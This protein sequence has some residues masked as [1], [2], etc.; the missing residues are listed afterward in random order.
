MDVPC[1]FRL[2][3]PV[4]PDACGGGQLAKRVM[5]RGKQSCGCSSHGAMLACGVVV[6]EGV[7]LFSSIA[8]QFPGFSCWFKHPLPSL[9]PGN[10]PV[11]GK[12]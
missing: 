2:S 8:G 12:L 1:L 5:E 11:A 9:P 3:L 7:R 6:A 4:Q 10:R